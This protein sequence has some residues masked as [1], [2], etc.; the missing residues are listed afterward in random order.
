MP[1]QNS[2]SRHTRTNL[3]Q[4]KQGWYAR[5]FIP[6]DLQPLVGRTE[7]VRTLRTKDKLEAHR[8]LPATI[9]EIQREAAAQVRP[10]AATN[11]LNPASVVQELERLEDAVRYDRSDTYFPSRRRGQYLATENLHGQGLI[12]TCSCVRARNLRETGGLKE[13]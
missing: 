1:T 10:A 13:R 9:A 3:I 2:A 7:V 11:Y 12:D 5:Y 6:K 8:R 4:R